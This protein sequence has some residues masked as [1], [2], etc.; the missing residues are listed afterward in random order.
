MH[1]NNNNRIRC[2]RYVRA[3]VV[4]TRNLPPTNRPSVRRAR[5][6]HTF[7][8]A[9]A[10]DNVLHVC[11]H[12]ATGGRTVGHRIVRAGSLRRSRT[13]SSRQSAASTVVVFRPSGALPASLVPH[14]AFVRRHTESYSVVCLSVV[15][16]CVCLQVLLPQPQYHNND[17]DDDTMDRLRAMNGARRLFNGPLR[18]TS[19]NSSSCRASTAH[20][21]RGAASVLVHGR[22]SAAAVRVFSTSGPSSSSGQI[23]LESPFGSC[24]SVD[25]T[26]PDYIWRNVDK[27]E[28]K[29]MIVSLA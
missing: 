29:P 7:Q 18:E 24:N 12:R 20:R 9:A 8:N 2:E 17:D 25:S 6:W 26:L 14:S 4:R 10:A 19:R 22:C 15:C 13:Y 23:I 3:C 1:N 5:T 27:W 16:V 21:H 11:L 28:D